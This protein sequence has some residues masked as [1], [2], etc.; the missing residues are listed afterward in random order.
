MKEEFVSRAETYRYLRQLNSQYQKQQHE[1]FP[2]KGGS[3]IWKLVVGILEKL[4]ERIDVYTPI[5]LKF[6]NEFLEFVNS[7]CGFL[8]DAQTKNVP[9]SIIPSLEELFS[10]VKPEAKFL[11]CPR[12]EKNYQIFTTNIIEYL[13]TKVI[14]IP[15][16]LF[17]KG[18]NFHTERQ[19]F[20]KEELHEEVYILFYPR[21]E[22]L[23]VLSFPL[24]GHE[25]G[26]IFAS[27][28]V[29]NNFEDTMKEHDITKKITRYLE[30]QDI[31][32]IEGPLFKDR[33]KERYI[34]KERP[35]LI[36][37]YKKIF[38]E[39]IADMVGAMIFQ[40]PALFSTYTFSL[41]F[42]KDSLN[43][44][45]IGYL[46][47]RIR[48]YII[49]RTLSYIGNNNFQKNF[50]GAANWC[51]R[52]NIVVDNVDLNNFITSNIYYKYLNFLLEIIDKK[53][54]EIIDD[55]KSIIPT[56]NFFTFSNDSFQQTVFNRLEHDIIPN[57]TI[58]NS[59]I[60]A[61]IDL[62][63][64]I[65]GLW[66]YVCEQDQQDQQGFYFTNYRANLLSL[67]GIEMSHLQRKARF[68]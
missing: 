2:C 17:D 62:R 67:K 60:E 27:K 1:T 13:N 35:R 56:N 51:K 52:I 8:D 63:N 16:L 61:P 58:D 50:K 57:C 21:N 20:F 25:I 9:W 11:I 49:N 7:L 12:W 10:E 6:V 66:L 54:K 46:P 28:W 42:D 68:I 29:D 3:I 38:R 47:W 44:V 33:N 40:Y 23:S 30:Q 45:E 59:L 32:E 26:H 31:G 34:F 4:E 5:T 43:L 64:I 55:I 18:P 48:L 24:L 14:S 39:V 65:T 37:V 36:N 15:G 53:L 41:R 22:R 19:L